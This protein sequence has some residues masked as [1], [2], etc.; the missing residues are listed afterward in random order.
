[1][2]S[3]ARNGLSRFRLIPKLF[4]L[5]EAGWWGIALLALLPTLV[6]IVKGLDIRN[7]Y[8]WA[9]LI[10]SATERKAD[11]VF[12]LAVL[13]AAVFAVSAL[14]AGFLRFT[15]ELLGLRWRDWLTRHLS[16]RYLAS[17]AYHRIK[18]SGQLDNPDQRL[19]EDVKTF[20]T[21]TLAILLIM[22]NATV[23]LLGFAGV[24]WSITPWLLVGAVGYAAFGT[25]MTVL[26]GHRL[27]GL[28]VQQFKKEADYRYELVRVREHSGS[29]ALLQSE[30]REKGRLRRRLGQL[31]DNFRLIIGVNRN[32]Y[33][34]TSW[35]G[36]MTQ[37]IPV[38]ITVPLYIRGEIEFGQVLQA[39]VGF[40][41]VLD[42][43]SLMVKEF[44]KITTFAAVVER[45]GAFYEAT[46]PLPQ[47]AKG[48]LEIA[49][50]DSRL[51]YDGLTL[52]TPDDGR[53]LVAD[54][55]LEI[56]RGKR[57][58]I[59][60]PDGSGR[61]A[62]M[63]ATAGLWKAGQGRILRPPLERM[64]FLPQQPYLTLGS[65][66]DQLLYNTPPGEPV[67][68]DRLLAVL[69]DVQLEPLLERVG[70]L[71]VEQR[72][73]TSILTLGEQQSLAFARL[74]LV[75]PE[76]AFLDEAVSALSAKRVRSLYELLAQ[77]AT[78]Y[79]SVGS[80]QDLLE[81]HDQVLQLRGDGT[82][83]ATHEVGTPEA[84][85]SIVPAPILDSLQ[86][87]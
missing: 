7:S 75:V 24:L 45:L 9:D 34:F 22:M 54:L 20:T 44:Q 30:E 27:V 12:H 29:I 67:S 58:L 11:I 36:Y 26:L 62:L 40:N 64:M 2:K 38:L 78:T 60:G 5:P 68:D 1:M 33:F 18:E 66:R 31:L 53:L 74:L 55:S 15:E 84:E 70:G 52:A 16:D 87:G 17:R 63:R 6:L 43:F 4:F 19:S 61:T 56:P 47:S 35:Y 32:L 21:S 42:A 39:Q 41:F 59:V 83:T 57:L 10:T 71:D 46:E 65:L 28:D 48:S 50:D 85:W 37:L 25:L 81:Y 51:A 76:F 49:E 86:V 23:A 13:Y 8:V 82:W 72:D 3:Q 69:Q 14:V 73:W 77:T 79:I 80:E